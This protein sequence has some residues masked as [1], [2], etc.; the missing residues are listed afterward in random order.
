MQFDVNVKDSYA[1][2]TGRT[3]LAPRHN[4]VVFEVQ[5]LASTVPALKCLAGMLASLPLSAEAKQLQPRVST[6][7]GA[8]ADICSA[9]RHAVISAAYCMVRVTTGCGR[10]S[11]VQTDGLWTIPCTRRCWIS[12]TA[13]VMKRSAGR[14]SS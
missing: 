9:S 1:N 6:R 13:A 14:G 2:A 7:V 12:F 3:T 11:A 8:F 5:N 4:A 10:P